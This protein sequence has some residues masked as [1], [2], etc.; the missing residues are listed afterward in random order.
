MALNDLLK[1]L[2]FWVLVVGLVAFV[3]KF[4]VPAF[5]FDESII[6]KFILFLLGLVNIHPE[7]KARGLVK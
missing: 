5:P 2:N 7:L 6:L 1:S 3:V 4:F